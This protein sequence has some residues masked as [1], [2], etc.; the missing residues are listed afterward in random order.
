MT[1]DTQ[2]PIAVASAGV[3]NDF[4][5][6]LVGKATAGKTASL[7]HLDDHKGVLYLNC[8]SG[9]KPPFKNDFK[10]IVVT[11]PYAVYNYFQQLIDNPGKFHT[12]VIDSITYLMDMFETMYVIPA[13][14]TRAAWGAYAQ[15]FKK[16]MQYYIPLAK[17][18]TII[19]AHTLDTVNKESIRETA[20]PIK[21]S[22]KNTGIESYF[23]LVI[24]AKRMSVHSLSE[25]KNDLLTIT[26]R[27]KLLKYKHVLQTD[28]TPDT[29]FERLRAPIGLFSPEE[30]FIDGNI[31]HVINRL[32]TFYA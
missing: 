15:Y 9:K 23:S 5:I 30:T 26:D 4:L 32:K 20:I 28:L 21:G 24:A 18:V 6:G 2:Q 27:E 13:E 19:T 31:Q 22:L 25:Y 11:D 10:H 14:D 16:L 3:Q 17:R 7:M 29:V 1:E 8:E 12:V